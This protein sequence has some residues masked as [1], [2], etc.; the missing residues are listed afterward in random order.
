MP[1]SIEK[2]QENAFLNCDNLDTVY[3]SGSEE[4]RQNIQPGTALSEAVWHYNWTD[5]ASEEFVSGHLKYRLNDDNVSY[6]V[7]GYEDT[8]EE[9]LVIPQSV[10][11]LP[12]TAIGGFAFDGCDS[13]KSVVFPDS[14]E[15]IGRYAFNQCTALENVSLSENLITIDM[16]AFHCCTALSE[17]K[18]PVSLESIGKRAFDYCE[19]LKMI[20]IPDKISLISEGTFAYCT[21]LESVKLPD[22]I[23][24]ISSYAFNQCKK[25]N[26]I[27]LPAT[28]TTLGDYAFCG[29]ETL[30]KIVIPNG[31]REMG[32]YTFSGCTG[33]KNINFPVYLQEI[34]EGCFNGCSSLEKVTIP[35][36][37]Q[38][39]SR[40]AFESCTNLVTVE[41][42]E[43]LEFIGDSVFSRCSSLKNI[44]LPENLRLLGKGTFYECSS[45]ETIDIPD[46]V[47]YIGSATFADCDNLV[48]VKMPKYVK[49]I[50]ANAFSSCSKLKEI[51]LP[52]T[53][54]SIGEYAFFYCENMEINTWP[55][56]LKSIEQNAFARCTSLTEITLMPELE[57]IGKF[58][59]YAC[60]ELKTVYLPKSV[61]TI[62]YAAF[63]SC[64]ELKNVYYTETEAFRTDNM[65]VSGDNDYL[66][67]AEWTFS[68]QRSEEKLA[69][70]DRFMV[71]SVIYQVDE[72]TDRC[73]V[74]G[75]TGNEASVTIPGSINGLAVYAIG[76]QAFAE[77]VRISDIVLGDKIELIGKYA[78]SG[79]SSLTSITFPED[80]KTIDTGAFFECE[81]L[82]HVDLPLKLNT[83]GVKAFQSSGLTMLVLPENVSVVGKWAFYNCKNLGYV[84]LSSA[85][86]ILDDHVFDSCLALTEISLPEGMEGISKSVFENCKNLKSILIP[87]SLTTIGDDAFHGCTGLYNI[88]YAGTE[89]Q[90]NA[91]AVGERNDEFQ[92]A[93]WKYQQK[94][95]VYEPGDIFQLENLQYKVNEDGVSCSVAD[96]LGDEEHVVVPESVKGYSVTVI[97]KSAFAGQSQLKEIVIPVHVK[98][99]GEGAFVW[100]DKLETVFLPQGLCE[101]GNIAFNLCDNISTVNYGGTE[102][103]RQKIKNAS[104]YYLDKATWNYNVEENGHDFGEWT[105]SREASCIVPGEKTRKCSVCDYYQTQEIPAIGH[106]S[107][108]EVIVKPTC[109]EEGYTTYICKVCGDSY[110][111]NEV[112]ALG[113]DFEEWTVIKEA[114]CTEAGEKVRKCLRCDY[115]ESQ[116]IESTGHVYE[117]VVTDPTCTENG[118]TTFI[119]KVCGDSYISEEV[120]ALGHD[121]GEWT[122]IKEATCTETG[123]KVR[124]CLRCDYSERGEIEALGHDYEV[125]VTDPTC[126]ENG[127]TTFTCK[128]CGDS[129]ISE[130]VEA[131]GHDFGEWTIIKEAS[132]T[133]AGEKVH[134]CNRC[135]YSESEEIEAIGHDYEEVVTTATCIEAGYITYTCKVCGDSYTDNKVEAL[136]HDLGEWTVIKEASCTESGE[137]VRKCSRCDYSETEEIKALGHDYEA[138]VTAPTCTEAGYT[139]YTCKNCGDSYV[140]DEVEALGHALGEW[141]VSKEASCTEAGEKIRKCSRC[142][143]SETEEIEATGH[144]YESVVTAPTCTEKGYTTYTCKVC[145]D[146]YVS[147]EVEALGHDLGEWTVSKEAS[148]MG[149]GEKVRKCSRCDYSETEEIEA[150]GHDYEIVVTAPTCC[151]AG[152]TKYTCKNCG[153][154]YVADEVEGLGHDLGEWTVSKEATCTEA[155]QKVRKCSRCDYSETEKIEP[156]GHDY[157]DGTCTKCGQADPDWTDTDDSYT[158]R[159][160]TVNGRTAW[161]YANEKGKVDTT[162]TGVRTNGYG[163][164]FVRN[165]EVDFSYTGLAQSETGWWRIVNGAVDFNCTSVVNSEYGWWY[166]RN[167]QIDF[168]YTG[169]AQ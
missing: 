16:R 25:L 71:D 141:T 101:I 160:I 41:L 157:V 73:V 8:V 136:G 154:T 130:E 64:K 111:V 17:I 33:L 7:S 6:M 108:E 58:A 4:D 67:G 107:Y 112:G 18:L 43:E 119:C 30:E 139:T 169:V 168:G 55:K 142:N 87:E 77:N 23:T 85:L 126:T 15:S 62:E 99:I 63:G 86:K 48:S 163:W 21:N 103:M 84:I 92:Q 135:D 127:Y 129:Y 50:G 102:A 128:V 88:L 27:R 140:A 93:I 78:F 29:C 123:E 36:S 104:S 28:L 61:N 98:S 146:S 81:K 158:L 155:G 72:D 10:N 14:I 95:F 1:K 106:H 89:E 159:Y 138:V 22:T 134:R 161:Y 24:V 166:V 65:N 132:C 164:W 167:G 80:L 35:D 49:G 100:C 47:T 53:I 83:I 117:A 57:E 40:Y 131:L 52:D 54:T 39:I 116:E 115:S 44:S 110:I 147:D 114:S 42:P 45:L 20:V 70:G 122:I 56:G 121:F 97:G 66:L 145:G 149:V 120:E 148:C 34:S 105:V 162:Y 12:V 59:F 125:V 156:T 143:Y 144:D 96:Y 124:K 60:W 133:E 69:A 165:G 11:G 31:V 51:N 74:V 3:Y 91:I 152:Y 94:D 13:L 75:Y 90:K 151:E 113:H 37:V 118:Y 9:N 153:D 137:K 109:T 76:N 68:Y 26:P 82:R 19:N 2:I 5:D 38:G 32:E 79:C 150:T 46:G